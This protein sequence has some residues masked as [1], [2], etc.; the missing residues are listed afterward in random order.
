[1][2]CG[3]FV[4]KAREIFAKKV[5]NYLLM[6]SQLDLFTNVCQAYLRKTIHYQII[7]RLAYLK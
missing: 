7:P 4:K 3:S 2:K 5:K 1:M 6:W